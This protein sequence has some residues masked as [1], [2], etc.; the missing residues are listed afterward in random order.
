MFYGRNGFKKARSGTYH[1]EMDITG[2]ACGIETVARDGK[3]VPAA[4][5]PG[6]KDY[7]DD[8]RCF[9]RQTVRGAYASALKGGW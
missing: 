8:G 1:I 6:Y 5:C 7:T 4:I 9:G 3:T 2:G